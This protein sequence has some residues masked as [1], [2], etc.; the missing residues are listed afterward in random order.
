MSKFFQRSLRIL[1]VT[2]GAIAGWLVGH[3]GG[4]LRLELPPAATGLL[5]AVTATGLLTVGCLFAIS[6]HERRN[7]SRNSDRHFVNMLQS[8]SQTSARRPSPSQ[9]KSPENGSNVAIRGEIGPAL[10]VES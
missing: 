8:Q 9:V 4:P 10:V 5:G 3:A 6:R 7:L 1:I 2:V